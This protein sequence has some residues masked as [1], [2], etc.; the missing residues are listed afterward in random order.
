MSS[1]G[2]AVLSGYL[3]KRGGKAGNKG[4]KKRWFIL[5]ADTRTLLYYRSRD[6]S[7]H[8]LLPGVPFRRRVSLMLAAMVAGGFFLL[9]LFFF[10]F[11]FFFFFSL[12]ARKLM[13]VIRLV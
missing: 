5:N 4:W 9:L 6:V 7:Q 3:H 12:C 1:A 11:F 10:F 13:R 2:G 8:R